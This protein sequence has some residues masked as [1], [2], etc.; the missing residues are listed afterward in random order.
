MSS[1]ST[2]KEEAMYTSEQDAFQHILT[3][4]S[5][6]SSSSNTN[7][8]KCGELACQMDSTRQTLDN[9]ILLSYCTFQEKEIIKGKKK[10]KKSSP[11]KTSRYNSERYVIALHDSIFYPE[12]GGQ[13]S[14]TGVLQ[15]LNEEEEED[16][17]SVQKIELIVTKATNVNQFCLL[18][19][20]TT[21][22]LSC[23]YT[24]KEI[25]TNVLQN[26]QKYKIKQVVDWNRRFDFM[27]Q[28]SAQH[29]ISAIALSAPYNMDTH[30][31][32]LSSNEEE[33]EEDEAIGKGGS[34]TTKPSYVDLVCT[35]ANFVKDVLEIENL[36]NEKIQE[37]LNMTPRYMDPN[38]DDDTS[39]VRSRLLP[40]GIT[41]KIRLVEIG[42]NNGS[43]SIDCN[44]C[45]GTHVPSLSYLQMISFFKIER[46]KASVIRVHFASS[47]R[48]RR[49]N[50]LNYKRES[51]INHVLSC[52][53]VE[54][55]GRIESLMGEKKEMEREMS[56]WKERVCDGF[57]EEVLKELLVRRQQQE[58]GGDVKKIVVTLDVGELDMPWMT[59]LE[60]NVIKEW[61]ARSTTMEGI[62]VL[63]V[64]GSPKEEDAG[65]F[66][67]MGDATLVSEGGKQ[68][69][70]ILNGRGGGRSGKFQGKGGAIRSKLEEA[71][72]MLMQL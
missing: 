26:S 66:Y 17:D 60:Q 57:M 24:E 36:V 8:A 72:E 35:K 39:Q 61:T 3:S 13:P 53:A 28:H 51:E 41:G 38:D 14:D 20:A 64:G 45:A 44:T 23:N 16:D 7:I 21:T 59:I 58:E 5:S 4:L 62:V 48:L 49:I 47:N 68:V 42:S 69:A 54:Q 10:K 56:V 6:S 40:D 31:F 30:S 70:Q 71:K 33:G 50:A 27:T 1:T 55:V 9:T 19:C 22:L 46:V 32:K 52:Q 37:N 65:N 2:T 63:M 18:T 67:L 25:I 29:L 11:P 12:G 43:S 34:I 15:L